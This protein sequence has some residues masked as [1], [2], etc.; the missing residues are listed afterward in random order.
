MSKTHESYIVPGVV[1]GAVVH[2]QAQRRQS[3]IRHPESTH[4][5]NHREGEH[6]N[7]GCTFYP[8]IHTVAEES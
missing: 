5:H 2:A 3:D 4:V 6:C 7:K 8:A 1:D